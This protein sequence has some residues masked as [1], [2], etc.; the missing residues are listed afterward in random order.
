MVSRDS[1]NANPALAYATVAASDALSRVREHAPLVRRMARHLAS[2]LPASVE[3]DDIIQAGMIGLMD[4]ANRFE[5]SY[6]AQFETFASQ[7]IRGAMLD[8]LRKNDWL[9]RSTRKALRQIEDAVRNL[10]QRLGRPPTEREIAAQLRLPLSEYQSLLQE[11][12]GYELIHVEDFGEDGYLDQHCADG[13]PNPLES[14][15]DANFRTSLVDAIE[16]LPEREKLVM[17]LYYEEDLNFREIAAVLEV[18]ESRVC[19][20]HSQAIARLRAKM[21]DW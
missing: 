14:L 4:A 15:L 18:T 10:E 21:R 7:R 12:K 6:D 20:I 3:I 2:R 19:Q 5:E 16:H 13:A 1:V 9:P 11:A 17:G 8:E